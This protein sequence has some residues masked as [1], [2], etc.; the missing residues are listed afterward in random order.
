MIAP[1]LWMGYEVAV[2]NWVFPTPYVPLVYHSGVWATY[3]LLASLTVTP[4]RKVL[5]WGKLIIIRRIVGVSA[6]FY[7]LAHIIIWFG[8]R[9]WDWMSL[10]S[11]FMERTTLLVAGAA[12]AGLIALGLTSFDSAI[13][14][15]GAR[16]WNMLHRSVYVVAGLAV[17]HFMLSPGSLQGLPFALAGIYLW[18]MLWRLLNARGLGADPRML[19]A[20]AV[21]VAPITMLLE[22]SWAVTVHHDRAL[23]GFREALALNFDPQWWEAIGPNPVWVVLGWGLVAVTG[24]VLTAR[25]SRRTQHAAAVQARAD[26]DPLH[27]S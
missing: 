17:L 22:V 18:L 15:M 1:A 5:R 11:E 16:R 2:G 21:V 14:W 23:F 3:L 24:A 6:L 8:L 25:R 13:K 20:L 19:L 27:Q 10:T 26:A 12:T 7:T 9:F 4:A